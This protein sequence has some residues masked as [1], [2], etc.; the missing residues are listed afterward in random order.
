M[1]AAQMDALGFFHDA[2][3]GAEADASGVTAL[4]GAAQLLGQELNGP[5]V[6]ALKKNIM[7]MLFN[8]ESFGYIGSSRLG[9]D[10]YKD[11]VWPG[12]Q[13]ALRFENISDYVELSQLVGDTTDPS[14]HVFAQNSNAGTQNV[15]TQLQAAATAVASAAV[16]TVVDDT[17]TE[18]PPSSLRGFLHELRETTQQAAFSGVVLTRHP[19]SGYHNKY[20]GSRLDNGA[21]TAS[22]S[23]ATVDVLCATAS[24]VA[25]AIVALANDSS[26]AAV[27][28]PQPAADCAY[29]REIFDCLANNQTCDLARRAIGLDGATPNLPMSRYIGVTRSATSLTRPVFFLFQLLAEAVASARNIT[30]PPGLSCAPNNRVFDHQFVKWRVGECFNTTAFVSYAIS[31]AFASYYRLQNLGTAPEFRDGRDPRYWPV[32]FCTPF[33]C[34]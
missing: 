15:V 7:Y 23:S 16:T 10:I 20:Y 9:F 14:L 11:S 33:L 5:A 1:V 29:I 34:A 17:A 13:R 2:S 26:V 12:P 6:R 24:I 18:L 4:L 27:N 25:R 32:R 21:Q 28:L 22:S 8:G 31:P 19:S 3:F 30:V